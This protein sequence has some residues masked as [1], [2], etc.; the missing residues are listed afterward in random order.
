MEYFITSTKDI[1]KTGF[2]KA[3]FKLNLAY[4]FEVGTIFMMPH[5][6]EE[7]MIINE[8]KRKWYKRVIQFITFKLYKAPWEYKNES[9]NI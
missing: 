5:S 3:Y 9:E 8:P 1:I 6:I 2:T 7:F 4:A